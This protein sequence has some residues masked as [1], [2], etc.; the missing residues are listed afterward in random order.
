[1]STNRVSQVS[2]W[3]LAFLGV[4]ALTACAVAVDQ[5]SATPSALIDRLPSG[6]MAIGWI[7]VERIAESLTPEQWAEYLAMAEEDENWQD[8]ERFAAAM[9]FDPRTDLLQ[10]AVVVLPG[11]EDD[12]EA[13]FLMAAQF[14]RAQ[15]ESFLDEAETSSYEGQTIYTL[16][17]ATF[18]QFADMRREEEAEEEASEAAEGEASV[19][20]LGRAL[21]LLAGESE[22]DERA[23]LTILDDTTVA[24]GGEAAVR[25]AIDVDG[26]RHDSLKMDP[27]MN[28]LI[29]DV[30]GEGQIWFVAMS[31]TWD[32][33]LDE[34]QQSGGPVPAS[35][36]ES[37]ETMTLSMRLGEG[38][39]LRMV[40]IAGTPEDA[41]M[42]ADS[43]SG[44]IAMGKMMLQQ[45]EPELF[46]IV[47]RGI[48]VSSDDRNV[49][50]QADLTDAD[51]EVLRAASPKRRKPNSQSRASS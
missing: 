51:L 39:A 3:S 48:S 44:L 46:D 23:F 24:L 19:S 49:H 13:V 22:A 15:L 20:I 5:Q 14:D 41:K 36:I 31:E 6:A 25:L 32:S 47:D 4:T 16:D 28:D 38:L 7:D 43:L 34:L 40:G 12:I 29:S 21:Y 42:L 2:M 35:G 10:L 45:S 17:D 30:A 18:E 9:G 33:G 50:I 26:D 11:G 27:A 1:M 37:I 8:L